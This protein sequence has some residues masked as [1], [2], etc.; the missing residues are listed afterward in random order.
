MVRSF[1]SSHVLNNFM[2]ILSL[3]R[4]NKNNTLLK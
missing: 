3:F 2:M 4:E 1:K